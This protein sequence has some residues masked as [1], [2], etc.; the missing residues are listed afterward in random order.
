M[1][2]VN[3]KTDLCFIPFSKLSEPWSELQ[4]LFVEPTCPQKFK[5]EER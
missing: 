2:K 4:R 5:P 3:K 1:R